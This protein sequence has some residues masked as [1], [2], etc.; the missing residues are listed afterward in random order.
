MSLNRKTSTK[1]GEMHPR[2]QFRRAQW[3][4]LNGAWRFLFDE[5]G[6]IEH[7]SQITTWPLD[8]EVP[9][10]PETEKSGIADT[11]FHRVCWYERDFDANKSAG[12][13]LLLHFGAVDYV[14]RVWV[15]GQYIGS[16][17]GGHTPFN[18]DVTAA[19]K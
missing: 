5:S 3:T 14:A 9:F 19:L 15:N 10:A 11:G 6:N 8:I 4:S 7:P 16:H 13:R 12:H 1:R 2:P 18:F 17:Q